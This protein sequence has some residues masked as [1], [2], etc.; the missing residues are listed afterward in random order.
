MIMV[1]IY[2]LIFQNV[3]KPP[4]WYGSTY[5]V[6]RLSD[7]SSKT[8]KKSFFVFLGCYQKP[9]YVIGRIFLYIIFEQKFVMIISR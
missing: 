2:L 9:F 6:V 8:G 5:M 1:T 7:V 3:I 4:N